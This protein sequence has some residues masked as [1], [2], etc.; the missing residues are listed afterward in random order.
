[1]GCIEIDLHG[2]TWK[3]ARTTFVEVYSDAFD[4][5]GN[6]TVDQVRVIQGYGETGEGGVIRNQL[7][8]FCQRF[9]GYLEFTAGEELDGNRGWTIVT[10]RKCLPAAEE[11][12]AEEVRDYCIGKRTRSKIVGKFRRYRAPLVMRAIRFLEKQRRLRKHRK[13]GLIMY[14]AS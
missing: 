10:P 6:P 8:R 13:S 4:S 5:A 1:M 2:L 7:R 3:E 11:M 12:I 9:E 14:E